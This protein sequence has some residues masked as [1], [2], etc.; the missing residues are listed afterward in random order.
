MASVSS[1]EPSSASVATTPTSNAD[2]PSAVR[3]TGSRIATKPSPKSRIA[4]AAYTANAPWW[5]DIA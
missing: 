2:R 3:Y 5:G 1:A 4:R